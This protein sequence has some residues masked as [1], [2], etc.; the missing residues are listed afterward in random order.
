MVGPSVA[1]PDKII[2]CPSRLSFGDMI[3]FIKKKEV[4][5]R[6]SNFEKMPVIHPGAAGI[7]LGSRFHVVAVGQRPG[8]VRQFGV[9]TE[10]LHELANWLIGHDIDTV[11]MESTGSYWKG[12]FVILQDYGLNPVLVNGSQ[13]KNV[14]GRKSDVQDAQWIQRLH[15]LGLLN[16]SFIPDN[17][18][19]GLKQY[20]RH[21][22]KLQDNGADYIKK[23]QKAMRLMNIRLDNVLSD[24]VG[25]SGRAIIEAVISGEK[26]AEVLADKMDCR[27]RKGREEIIRALTGDWRDSYIF[28]LRQSY[29]LYQFLRRQI[30]ECDRAIEEILQ[31]V[32]ENLPVGKQRE[33][34]AFEPQKKSASIKT[35]QGSTLKNWL[36]RSSAPI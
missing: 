20:S 8:Q 3:F 21:R 30:A 36:L 11:A 4:M 31:Q 23:M 9:Y 15:S 27:V 16:G 34:G 5:G 35:H 22:Q 29:E 33:V 19:D 13:V 2:V 28:E 12:L 14:K 24:V 32:A 25:K 6:K 26:D 7:D 17:L 1:T 18:T 10:D